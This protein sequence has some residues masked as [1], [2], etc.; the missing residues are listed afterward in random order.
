MK[1]FIRKILRE[2]L[3]PE[4]DVDAH[5]LDR[6]GDRISKM[7]DEDL[8]NTIKGSIFST[9]KK[10]ENIDFPKNKSYVIFLGEFKANPKSQYFELF[11]GNPYYKI[12]GSIGNQFWV[13]VRDNKIDTFM[14]AM[15]YQTK[16]PEYNAKRLNVDLSIKNIDKFAEQL[17][18]TRTHNVKDEP[19]III[20]GVK[21]MVDIKDETIYK[22]NNPA[23]KHKI[24]DMLDSVDIATQEKVLSFF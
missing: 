2:S 5:T 19:I 12:E 1:W 11:R 20:N 3:L 22:K 15:D 9:L 16:N 4:A 7:S 18:K 6:V 13:I 24:E 14:L 8:P 21:W 10:I 23:V 17:A